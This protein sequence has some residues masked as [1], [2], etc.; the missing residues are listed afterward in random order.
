MTVPGIPK[1]MYQTN[2][3]EHDEVGRP[4]SGFVTHEK[5]NAK[6]YRKMEGV[7]KKY[8]LFRKFG[9]EKADLG[10]LCW[11]SSLGPVREA[12]DVLNVGGLTVGAFAPRILAP[13]PTAEIQ[14]FVDS[15]KEILI[16]ELSYSEQ[17]RQYLRSQIDLPRTKT[18][19]LARSGGKS[20][21]VAEVI[22]TVRQLLGA[23][24][25]A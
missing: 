21:A 3:L 20:L 12:V 22:D 9:A 13:L 4:N 19:V 24:V 6:R 15:C 1:G 10:I 8:K 11:E 5:M 17:F 18:H 14:E 16:V 7:A 23:E 25:L 2:G